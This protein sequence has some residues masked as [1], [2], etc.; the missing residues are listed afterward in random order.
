MEIWIRTNRRALCWGTVV[1]VALGTLGILL[2]MLAPPATPWRWIGLGFGWLL[3]VFSGLILGG[4]LWMMSIPRVAYDQGYVLFYLQLGPPVAVP[5]EALEIFLVGR[6]PTRSGHVTCV[7]VRI[8]DRAAQWH[9][10]PVS[11]SL[12][13]WRDGYVTIRGT[14]CEPVNAGLLK[15]LNRRLRELQREREQG[16]ADG[17]S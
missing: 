14:W 7:L 15:R 5:V 17:N 1:P 6:Q 2:V 12:A 8:K 9:E 13:T 10:W 16:D 4:L 3:I 11:P